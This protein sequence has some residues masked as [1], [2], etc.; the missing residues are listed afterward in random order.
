M[1][2]KCIP[3]EPTIACIL[4]P[5]CVPRCIMAALAMLVAAA[6]IDKEF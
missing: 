1:H 5:I 3:I 4:V 2:C 6:V